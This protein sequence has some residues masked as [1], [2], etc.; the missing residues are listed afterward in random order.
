MCSV[1]AGTPPISYS[2]LKDSSAVGTL[3]NVRIVHTDEYQDNLQIEKLGAEHVG[4]YTCNAK[5]LYGSDQMTV[6]IMIKVS[7]RWTVNNNIKD[8]RS[9]AGN[10]FS[11]D[12][13]VTAHPAAV[14]TFYKGKRCSPILLKAKNLQL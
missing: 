7:P 3:P 4:N 1:S 8:V 2:W 6:Q 11:I 12:C 10:N 5:N 13:R 14:V 9:V